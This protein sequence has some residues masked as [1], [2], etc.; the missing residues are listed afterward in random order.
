MAQTLESIDEAVAATRD[1]DDLK[2]QLE[3]AKHA[4]E[5]NALSQEI[6]HMKTQLRYAR[7]QKQVEF[8]HIES[9]APAKKERRNFIQLVS[10]RL[11]AMMSPRPV[12]GSIIALGLAT[13][14]LVMIHTQV[15]KED[16]EKYQYYI[17]IGLLVFAGSQIIKSG[18]RSLFLP[19]LATVAGALISHHLQAGQRL[20]SYDAGF[21]QYV[22]LV[23]IVGIGITV[24]NLE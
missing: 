14:A 1:I 13:F 16:L 7:H 11:V 15:L 24:L 18:F 19:L 3:Q 12:A 10:S 4:Q 22:M 17:G 21:Y 8:S 5:I 20:F 9:Q 2:K 23:G 6:D